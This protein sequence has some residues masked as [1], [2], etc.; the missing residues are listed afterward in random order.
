MYDLY[1]HIDPLC[2]SCGYVVIQVLSHRSTVYSWWLCSILTTWIHVV[3]L[4]AMTYV[5]DSIHLWSE[6]GNAY[7][8]TGII[9]CRCLVVYRF[10]IRCDPCFW[11]THAFYK[12]FQL[13]QVLAS[14]F[15]GHSVTHYFGHSGDV[16]TIMC[17]GSHKDLLPE[18]SDCCLLLQNIFLRWIHRLHVL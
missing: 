1:Q 4:V 17:S 14:Y 2:R 8:K 11:H 3:W 13:S 6:H 12:V 15:G 18:K 10:L 9:F 5:Y 7:L 16:S